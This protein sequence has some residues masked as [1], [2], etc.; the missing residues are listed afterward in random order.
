MFTTVVNGGI[1]IFFCKLFCYRYVFNCLRQLFLTFV[2][3]LPNSN[4]LWT[5][6]G[7]RNNGVSKISTA[8]RFKRLSAH[9]FREYN[10][11][12]ESEQFIDLQSTNRSHCRVALYTSFFRRHR[13]KTSNGGR[14]Y[15]VRAQHSV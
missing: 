12:I 3:Q 1:Y 4:S 2:L 11:C 10:T 9:R 13:E 7:T 15:T 14:N 8:N 5:V 6:N